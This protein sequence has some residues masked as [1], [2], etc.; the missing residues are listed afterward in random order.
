[1]VVMIPMGGDVSNTVLRLS[2]FTRYA[3]F[4][5]CIAATRRAPP[6]KTK[7]LSDKEKTNSKTREGGWVS[8]TGL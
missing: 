8:E 4:S 1:M 7:P 5:A 3:C 6:A 2:P